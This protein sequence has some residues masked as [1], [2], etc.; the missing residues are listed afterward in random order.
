MKSCRKNHWFYNN[1][2]E[3]FRLQAAVKKKTDLYIIDDF[4]K[5]VIKNQT[6]IDCTFFLK[7]IVF[8]QNQ[9]AKF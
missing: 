4:E 1:N 2:N 3:K 9:M 8:D 6:Q 5:I 7:K